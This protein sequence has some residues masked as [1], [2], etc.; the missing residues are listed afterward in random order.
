MTVLDPKFMDSSLNA[1]ELSVVA[2]CHNETQVLEEFVERLV[3]S[4]QRVT[5]KFEI[6]LIDDGS[7]DETWTLI[8][9][10]AKQDERVRGL[11]LS[12]NFGHQAA[13]LAGLADSS[14][15]AIFMLDADLQDPPEMLER[16]WKALRTDD[17]DVVYAKRTAREGV[18]LP[19]QLCYRSFYWVLSRACGGTIPENVGDF[20]LV[21]RRALNVVLSMGESQPFLRGMF[22]WVGFRQCCVEYTR[23]PRAG[24]QSSYSWP[25]L[26]KLALDGVLGFSTLPLRFASVCAGVLVAISIGLLMW[27]LVGHYLD[28]DLPRGWTSLI[29]VILFVGALQLLVLGV[30]GEYLGRVYLEA[31]QRPRFVV[32]ERVGPTTRGGGAR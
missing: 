32:A 31:K 22:S 23:G 6:V 5:S 3:S 9:D 19:L 18:S 29:A 21:T 12:R 11:R 25:K 27:V 28:P 4:C 1:P 26:V 15:D 7:D 20:R 30:I 2:P 24:G 17:A 13:L 8:T 16:M 10:L 14:G